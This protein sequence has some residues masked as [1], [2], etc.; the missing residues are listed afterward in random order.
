MKINKDL[1]DAVL[2]LSVIGLVLVG[3]SEFNDETAKNITMIA[4]GISAV[5]T[6]VLRL[7]GGIKESG[8]SGHS[9]INQQ[10][11]YVIY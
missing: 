5:T 4:L 10:P 7:I 9:H 11:F 3:T 6:L 8:K 1:I 2:M